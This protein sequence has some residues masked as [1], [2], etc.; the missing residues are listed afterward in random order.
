MSA[1]YKPVGWNP[2][3]IVYDAV[4]RQTQAKL[5]RFRPAAYRREE[6]PESFTRQIHGAAV[7]FKAVSISGVEIQWLVIRGDNA[8]SSCTDRARKNAKPET[9]V[10]KYLAAG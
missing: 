7:S 4:P 6:L 1:R 8:R 9:V 3:K 5:A 10:A 2:T